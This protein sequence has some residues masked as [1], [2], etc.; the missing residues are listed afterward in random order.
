VADPAI[1]S[2]VD[3]AA[4]STS[5]EVFTWSA[6]VDI[7]FYQLLVGSSA[8]ASDYWLGSLLPSTRFSEGP[9]NLPGDGET[10]YVTLKWSSAGTPGSDAT[11]Y[12]VP[13]QPDY[14]K[15]G[16][17]YFRYDSPRWY[18]CER[19]GFRYPEDEVAIESLTG[20]RVCFRY[21]MN[22]PQPGDDVAVVS[23]AGPVFRSE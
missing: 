18:D 9:V 14:Q 8:G 11:T 4:L 22:Y 10:I 13:D 12:T 3:G 15:T 19:C 7:D 2:H 23:G 17:L 16:G 6:G 1:T 20:R 21:C 5:F